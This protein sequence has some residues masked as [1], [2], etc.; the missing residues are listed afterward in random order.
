M[1]GVQFEGNL[2]AADITTELLTGNIKGQTPADFGLP[3]SDKLED[4]IAIA[5]GDAKAYWASFQ[6]QLNRLD[7]EDTATS[8]TRE[9]AVLL[10]KSLGYTPVYTA[11]AEVV[12]GQ[13]YAISHRAVSQADS[14]ITNQQL[15]ITNYPPIHII[16]CRLDIDKRPPSGT[17]RLS[18]HGLVQ[19]YLNKTE[20]LWAIATNGFRWRL[21]RDSSLMTRLTYI[22]FD[23]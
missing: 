5:W 20:H 3:K 14:S 16:G 18:A 1:I 22:E 13:T 23:L 9:M 21:L 10:L 17:P 7:A 19:E 8:I 15:P 11:K 2:L 4:E 6:R 12:E